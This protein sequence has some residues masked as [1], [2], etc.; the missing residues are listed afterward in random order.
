MGREDRGRGDGGREEVTNVCGEGAGK[1][2]GGDREEGALT[3]L[4]R[5]G[6]GR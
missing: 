4:K 2:E 3:A 6:R 5:E 1:G